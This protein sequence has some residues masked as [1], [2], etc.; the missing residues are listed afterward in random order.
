MKEKRYHTVYRT[1]CLPNGKQYIGVHST[2]ILDDEYLGSS[3]SLK[4]DIRLFGTDC[5]D[6][7]ILIIYQDRQ[8]ALQKEKELVDL[9]WIHRKD[10]YNLS[11]GGA[12]YPHGYRV[13]SPEHRAKLSLAGRKKTLSPEHRTRI[14]NAT[15]GKLVS[16]ETRNKIR[17]ARLGKHLSDEARAKITASHRIPERKQ[18]MT[19]RRKPL[20]L[21]HRKRISQTLTERYHNHTI[22]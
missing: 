11:E 5:F 21:E 10:T 7:E 6:K 17:N 12:A 4:D 22:Q 14:S 13:F 2:D 1:T 3:K 9:C 15:R 8:L 18:K 20:S 16:P 19:A